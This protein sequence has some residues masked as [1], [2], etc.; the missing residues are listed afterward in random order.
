MNADPGFSANFRRFLTGLPV[1]G[2]RLQS[3][4]LRYQKVIQEIFTLP[5]KKFSLKLVRSMKEK[6]FYR[7][8]LE[9]NFSKDDIF[10]SNRDDWI[11]N[12]NKNYLRY[13]DI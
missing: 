7:R 11:T 5:L 1:M 9:N 13:S 6:H 12:K 4:V 8:V 2:N 10:N 3:E